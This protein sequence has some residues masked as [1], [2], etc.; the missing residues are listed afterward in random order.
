MAYERP[1]AIRP[2]KR[3]QRRR[4]VLPVR[5]YR[6]RVMRPLPLSGFPDTHV[7]RLRYC[8]EVSLDAA[9]ANIQAWAFRANSMYSP[10]SSGSGHQPSG[11]DIWME[12]YTTFTVLG[13]K[14][15]VTYAPSVAGSQIP[16]YMGVNLVTDNT[17]SYTTMEHMLEQV[18]THRSAGTVGASYHLVNDKR[19][20]VVATFSG[21]RWFGGGFKTGVE[22]FYGTLTGD[23]AAQVFFQVWVGS[24]GG[25]NPPAVNL[26]VTIDYIAKLADRRPIPE[27]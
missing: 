4:R 19:V 15:T 6:N 21:K 12:R 10:S 13:S 18:D 25:N 11:F 17:Q 20:D 8:Q 26:L 27:S 7:V 22:P 1:S 2:R 5:G 14:C 24:V 16:A 9:A 23:P 3:L